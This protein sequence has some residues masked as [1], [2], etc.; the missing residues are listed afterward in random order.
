MIRGAGR[1]KTITIASAKGGS[2]KT[3]C[4]ATLAAR[5]ARD[6]G[7]VAMLDLNQDQGNLTDW[8]TLRGEPKNP[9]LIDLEDVSEDIAALRES[10]CEWVFV[11]TPPLEVRL[12]EQAIAVADLVLIPVRTSLLYISATDAVTSLC[13]R[14]RKPFAFLLSAVDAKMPKLTDQAMHM[15]VRMAK[16]GGK[17]MANRMSYRQGYIQS[18]A[19][20]RAAYETEKALAGEVDG[21]WSEVQQLAESKR[22]SEAAQ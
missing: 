14:H 11:D 19:V 7:R 4:T 16:P 3:T 21:I 6:S 12:I 10:G 13:R 22:I 15:L 17:V 20:G 9:T 5:A 18:L 2:C 1:M 8:W